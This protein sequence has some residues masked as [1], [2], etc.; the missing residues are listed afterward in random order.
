[1]SNGDVDDDNDA[2]DI[3]DDNADATDA[4][5]VVDVFLDRAMLTLSRTKRTFASVTCAPFAL[6]L[7][8]ASLLP[9]DSNS[10]DGCES[11]PIE[12]G[13]FSIDLM[14]GA[15]GVEDVGIVGAAGRIS[16]EMCDKTDEVSTNSPTPLL[17][18]FNT[19]DSTVILVASLSFL[20]CPR[21][22]RIG[23]AV[24]A[25]GV[26]T[27]DDVLQIVGC[28]FCADFAGEVNADFALEKLTRWPERSATSKP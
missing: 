11:P 18:P 14:T 2:G 22:G 23:E 15:T 20:C 13:R 1:M 24:A 7:S 10:D 3:V 17:P 19:P 26:S 27:S 16:L 4:R 5:D 28:S 21:G 25:L 12:V 8:P 9:T 6:M